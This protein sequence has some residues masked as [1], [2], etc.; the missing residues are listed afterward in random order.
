[1]ISYKSDLKLGTP[2]EVLIKMLNSA[3]GKVTLTQVKSHLLEI[4]FG[5]SKI[6]LPALETS[7]KVWGFPNE[8]PKGDEIEIT[9]ALLGAFE[10]VMLARP[11]GK[12]SGIVHAGV[13]ALPGKSSWRLF[14]TDSNVMAVV[15]SPA[16]FSGDKPIIFPYPF[17]ELLLK[18]AEDG[19]DL[20]ISSKCLAL[21]GEKASIFAGVIDSS[22]LQTENIIR[23]IKS[24]NE[25]AGEVSDVP[26]EFFKVV[27]RAKTLV[28][29]AKGETIKITG[30]GKEI[31]ISG[32][33]T[34]GSLDEVL[35]CSSSMTGMVIMDPAI[36]LRVAD[37]AP[38]ISIVSKRGLIFSDEG[39][40]LLVGA[41]R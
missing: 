37:V 3:I 2:G 38:S 25:E 30:A 26:S 35:P 21:Y 29:N 19:D 40:Q 34:R 6:Q 5:R 14:A 12:K 16:V 1:M 13:I 20:L 18:H 11:G 28:G 41:K 23:I 32:E 10:T 39:L 24:F 7:R 4:A 31:K 15:K 33:L 27:E 9:K 17:V 36:L 22:S 8:A